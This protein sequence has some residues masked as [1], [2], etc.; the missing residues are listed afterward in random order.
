MEN[1]IVTLTILIAIVYISLAYKIDKLE[2]KT[3]EVLERI[4]KL[5]E[6]RKGQQ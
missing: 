5:I 3:L 4:I 1:L 6:E 2:K